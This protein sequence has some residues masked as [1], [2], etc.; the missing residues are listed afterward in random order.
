MIVR[1]VIFLMLAGYCGFFGTLSVMALYCYL[2]SLITGKPV[3]DIEA[4][5]LGSETWPY[6]KRANLIILIV[7]CAIFFW[8]LKHVPD[9]PN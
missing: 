9:R 6:N 3:R 4:Q 5:F 8:L 1:W 2:A 7:I